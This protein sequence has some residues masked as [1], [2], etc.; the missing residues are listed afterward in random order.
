MIFKID[1]IYGEGLDFEVL[2]SKK[3]FDIDSPE[4]SLT[5]D[6]KIQGKLGN[7]GQEILCN[8]LLETGLS[9]TCSRCLGD[10]SFSVKSKLRVHFLPRVEDANPANEIELNDLDFEQEFYEEG[11]INLSS[12]VR[13]L[14]LLSLPQI[15]LC[16]ENCAG[17]CPQCGANLNEKDCGC[18][19]QESCDPRLAVLQQLKDK[20][21]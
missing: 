3:H 16:K 1:E 5:E 11:Q 14:I 19:K 17:L 18:V 7:T 2:E 4:C 15:R 6:V 20:L 12:P 13:D 10:F 21:K 9:V 8:G